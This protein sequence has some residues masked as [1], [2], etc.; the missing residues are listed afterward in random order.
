MNA[1]WTDLIGAILKPARPRL[2]V[3]RRR[4]DAHLAD[5]RRTEERRLLALA[6]CR[7][8][9]EGAR[10]TVFA[11]GDGVVRGD[12]TALERE[13]RTLSR[14]ERSIEERTLALWGEI[15]PTPWAGRLRWTPSGDLASDIE[16]A[17]TLASDPIG[18][19]QAEAAARRLAP[20]ASFTWHVGPGPR[21]ARASEHLADVLRA[22]TDAIAPRYG[23]AA[24]LARADE[25]EREV[26]AAASD[27]P[28]IA[29]VEGLSADVGFV[30]R[31]DFLWRARSVDSRAGSVECPG[32]AWIDLWRT[33]YVVS[34]LD[35][36]AITLGAPAT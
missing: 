3:C 13:W 32:A 16:A 15:A 19:E 33:G 26:S 35:T 5:H 11:A 23:G 30:A 36:D 2:S 9:I 4:A 18:I 24:L 17:V 22:L 31:L 1:L 12:M 20:A 21:I 10:A 8:R 14:E 7:A 34:S 29:A 6:D 25:R 27:S 28:A